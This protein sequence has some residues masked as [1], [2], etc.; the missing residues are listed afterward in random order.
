MGSHF[1][2]SFNF[3]TDNIL[4]SGL[5]RFVHPGKSEFIGRDAVIKAGEQGLNWNFVTMQVDDVE[6]YDPRGSEALYDMEDNLIGRATNGAY[7]WRIGKSLALGMVKPEYSNEGQ[8]LQ[9]RML[10]KL[11][12]A[13][14]IGESPFDAANERLRG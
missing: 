12:K 5:H 11:Y 2:I 1:C 8:Q 7:G 3:S 14:V 10:G 13:T 6:N 4:E 9:I